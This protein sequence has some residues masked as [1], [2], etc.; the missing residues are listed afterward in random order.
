MFFMHMNVFII[1]TSYQGFLTSRPH[2]THLDLFR[3]GDLE[4]FGSCDAPPRKRLTRSGLLP[5]FF[6]S[7]NSIVICPRPQW[8]Q[9]CSGCVVVIADGM[10]REP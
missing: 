1:Q 4:P 5:R 10:G 6:V 2:W 8:S 9:V 3:Y 7:V